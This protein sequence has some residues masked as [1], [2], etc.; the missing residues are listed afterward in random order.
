MQKGQIWELEKGCLHLNNSKIAIVIQCRDYSKR[1]PYKSVIPFYKK[2]SILQIIMAK[3]KHLPYKII[4]TTTPTSFSTIGQANKAG[5]DVMVGEEGDVLAA[6]YDVVR[7][8]KLDGV[9]RVCADNPFI[10]LP[11]MFPVAVWGELEKLD[12]VAFDH[13]MQRKEG[14]WVEYISA[15]ALINA[16]YKSNSQ[17]DHEHVT[18]FIYNSPFRYKVKWLPIPPELEAHNIKLTVDTKN[19]FERAQVVYEDVGEKHWHYIIDWFYG[20]DEYE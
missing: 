15:H 5:V 7:K 2:K 8:Y 19:D 16:N 1:L 3:F 17:Y 13:A 14:F 9:F 4:V 12:Y 20:E 11:L 6:F 10:Q 18:P